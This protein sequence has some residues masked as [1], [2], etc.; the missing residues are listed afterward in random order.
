MHLKL[1]VVPIWQKYL[2]LK[3]QVKTESLKFINFFWDHFFITTS[4]DL[5]SAKQF[6]VILS[7]LRTLKAFGQKTDHF[8]F[9]L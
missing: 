8:N 1:K 2:F 4:T 5:K 9:L 3:K 6:G 7:L